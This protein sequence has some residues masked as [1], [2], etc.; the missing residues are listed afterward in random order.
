MA[1]YLHL[2]SVIQGV[3]CYMTSTASIEHKKEETEQLGLPRL[4][5]TECGNESSDSK[6][7]QESEEREK[8]SG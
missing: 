7:H 6:Q 1:K 5:V 8:P 3:F 2:I 4:D